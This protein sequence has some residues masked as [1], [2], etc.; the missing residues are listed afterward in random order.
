MVKHT[1]K[2]SKNLSYQH[3]KRSVFMENAVYY[4]G[5]YDLPTSIDLIQYDSHNITERELTG[6][7]KIHELFEPNKISWF[8]IKGLTDVDRIT[9]ICKE[10]GIE[11]FDV[12]NLFSERCDTKVVLYPEITFVLMAG[13]SIDSD[14]DLRTE[15]IAFILGRDF[16]ISFQ[17]SDAP[18]FDEAITALRNSQSQIREKGTDFLLGV[19]FNSVYYQFVDT[20]YKLIEQTAEI[21][22]VLIDRIQPSFNVMKTI[23]TGK[24][25]YLSLRRSIIPLREELPNLMHNTNGLI[26]KENLMYF[27]DFDDR[28]RSAISDLEIYNESVRSLLEIYYSNN[29]QRMNDIMKRLTIVST[30]FIPLTFMVGVWGMNFRVMPE[31]EWKYGYLF[32]W[33]VMAGIA[34]L[35]IWFLKRK[36]WF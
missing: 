8:K 24:N 13:C 22:D 3:P 17:E 26:K 12:K 4:S 28:L 21:E 34:S 1:G 7:I 18:I 32:A 30:I 35:A 20:I 11:Q 6:E 9:K 27:N 36:K 14:E 23:R 33:C 31:T 29:N 5:I 25:N 2:K 16:V 15:Q 10:C 19:L